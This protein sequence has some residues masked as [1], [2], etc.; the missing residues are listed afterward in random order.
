MGTLIRFNSSV[1]KPVRRA[2]DSRAA[3]VVIFPG[4]RIERHDL[5]LGH[6]LRDSVGRQG[7]DGMGN[8]GRRPKRTS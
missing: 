5:D 3:E 6:R 7:L 2:P 4:V 1:R 8:G